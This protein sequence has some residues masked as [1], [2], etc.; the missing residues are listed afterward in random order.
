MKRWLIR[1]QRWSAILFLTLASFYL[2][3]HFVLPACYH[4]LRTV[5]PWLLPFVLGWFL[6]A[7]LDPPVD[8]LER[9]ARWPRTVASLTLVLLTTA[10][11]GAAA[12]LLVSQVTMELWRLVAE[13]PRYGTAL[14]EGLQQLDTL[15]RSWQLPPQVL[16][17]TETSIETLTQYLQ[18]LLGRLIQDLVGLAA[19]IPRFF[20]ALIIV[21]VSSFF[22]SRDKALIRGAF[23]SAFPWLGRPQAA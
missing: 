5:I 15:Y 10:L 11:V 8:W 14:R 22:F 4:I 13:L 12:A 6:A 9:R 21:L 1:A 18:Q 7:L 23:L 20:I 19:G 17:A 2:L 3:Y 16:E